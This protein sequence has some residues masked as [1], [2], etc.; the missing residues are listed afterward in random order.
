[1]IGKAR[2]QKTSF[3]AKCLKGILINLIY[4][5]HIRPD[6]LLYNAKAS[7]IQYLAGLLTYPHFYR[8]PIFKQWH[9]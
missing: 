9:Y 7:S 4:Y 2:A 3:T 1:M 5:L 8:L 6:Q